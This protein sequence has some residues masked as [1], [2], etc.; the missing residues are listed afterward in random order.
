LRR[1]GIFRIPITLD[2]LFKYAVPEIRRRK[3]WLEFVKTGIIDYIWAD[4]VDPA[5]ALYKVICEVIEND[6]ARA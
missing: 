5:Q 3:L 6:R 4:E 1:D 2:N